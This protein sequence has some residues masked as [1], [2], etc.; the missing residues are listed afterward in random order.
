LS[1]LSALPAG[2]CANEVR[3]T[4]RTIVEKISL[5]M[6]I[7]FRE[8]KDNAHSFDLNTPQ[9]DFMVLLGTLGYF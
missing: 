1:P 6:M 4:S 2:G 7:Y 9:K 3:E 5:F 8:D